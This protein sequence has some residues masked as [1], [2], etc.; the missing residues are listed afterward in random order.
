M[1]EGVTS[2][3]FVGGVADFT[4][5]RVNRP[6]EKLTLTFR[7]VPDRF[8]AETSVLFRVVA[9]PSGTEREKVGFVLRGDVSNLPSESDVLDAIRRELGRSLDVD[10]SRILELSYEVCLIH[11]IPQSKT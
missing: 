11:V 9:P 10:V 6:S 1:L 8:R 5:L 7:T 2:V 3:P 4:R